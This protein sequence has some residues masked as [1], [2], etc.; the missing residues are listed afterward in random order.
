[1]TDR[2]VGKAIGAFLTLFGVYLV[3][4]YCH[5]LITLRRPTL[6]PDSP[7][8]IVTATLVQDNIPADGELFLIEARAE[9]ARLHIKFQKMRS[10]HGFWRGQNTLVVTEGASHGTQP[11][12]AHG[13][14]V[15]G[16]EFI[17]TMRG[18]GIEFEPE[19]LADLPVKH[20]YMHKRIKVTATTEVI[21]PRPSSARSFY[22]HQEGISRQFELL[23]I[24]AQ[25]AAAIEPYKRWQRVSKLG[26]HLQA[27]GISLL[28]ILF[29]VAVWYGADEI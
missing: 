23:V 20:E 19:L 26:Y 7:K 29:G 9:P 24:S 13:G 5:T 1:M 2:T 22:N 21:C 27:L 15:W 25:E 11:S 4:L 17:T 16:Q 28:C 14:A 10:I 12:Y 3:G 8:E 18:T 6:P